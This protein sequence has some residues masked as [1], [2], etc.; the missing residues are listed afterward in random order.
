MI[1]LQV[2]PFLKITFKSWAN[3]KAQVFKLKQKYKALVFILPAS[4]AIFEGLFKYFMQL[5]ISLTTYRDFMPYHASSNVC[6]LFS[7]L[8]FSL[9]WF[10]FVVIFC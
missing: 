3:E 2:Y 9:K 5:F 4:V 10:I 6:L 1:E 7:L 8:F